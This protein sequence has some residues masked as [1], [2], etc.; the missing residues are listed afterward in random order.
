MSFL[1]EGQRA[2]ET[3]KDPLAFLD[4]EAKSQ[5]QGFWARALKSF[6]E[7]NLLQMQS[8]GPAGAPAF[9]AASTL[10]TGLTTTSG[11]VLTFCGIAVLSGTATA[12]LQ[13]LQANMWQLH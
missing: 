1:D 7:A 4:E 3:S 5:D 13:L 8:G 9:G 10:V 11:S 6:G 2:N 12:T